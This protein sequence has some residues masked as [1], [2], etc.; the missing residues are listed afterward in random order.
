MTLIYYYAISV[1]IRYEALK[2]SGVSGDISA[3]DPQFCPKALSINVKSH[4]L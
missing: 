1:T 2:S 3:A 4:D